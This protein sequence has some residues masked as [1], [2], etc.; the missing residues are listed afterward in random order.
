MDTVGPMARTVKDAAR[1]LAV[2]AGPDPKDNYTFGIPFRHTPDYVGA[3]DEAALSNKRIGIPRNV[4][5]LGA[6]DKR[7][8]VQY[9]P[10]I[11][12][13]N[14]SL[15]VLREA[16]AELVDNVFLQGHELLSSAPLEKNALVGGFASALASYLAKLTVNPHGITSLDE[17]RSFTQRTP[18]EDWPHYGTEFWDEI[19]DSNSGANDSPAG[20]ELF[21]SNYNAA[22]FAAGHLGITGALSNK[23]LDA[24]VLPTGFSPH[25][26]AILG[27]PLVTVPLGA[28][29]SDFPL[30]PTTRG[31]LN[32]AAPNVPFGISFLGERFSE[33][34]LV[35]MA[36]AFEQ[37]TH[38]RRKAVP[39]ITPHTELSDVVYG[40]R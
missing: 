18:A 26:P 7:Q 5:N 16:G 32:S 33:E 2:I 30:I 19:L 34:R 6:L 11:A 21:W 13:F 36:Y 35:G 17:L 39:Y 3:C 24:L 28:Y 15:H 29:P 20:S 38:A 22:V 4:F 23:S 27:S 10:V 12:A 8:Q 31:N 25:L 14:A 1:V 9:E 40:N 37:R